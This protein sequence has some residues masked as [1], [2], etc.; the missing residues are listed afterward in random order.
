M[1]LN[2]RGAVQRPLAVGDGYAEHAPTGLARQGME[3]QA[4][5]TQVGDHGNE[6][7]NPAALRRRE[8]SG[9]IGLA[10]ERQIKRD[11][12]PGLECGQAGDGGGGEGGAHGVFGRAQGAPL[13]AQL[14]PQLRFIQGDG[15]THICRFGP[16]LP[17]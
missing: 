12:G 15:A 17:T 3:T 10:I 14:F 13:A 8:E 5:M 16:L 1:R 2:Q 4:A 6:N 7:M 9:G 11:A